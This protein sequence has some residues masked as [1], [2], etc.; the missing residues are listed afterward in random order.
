MSL[1][2][3]CSLVKVELK[4]SALKNDEKLQKMDKRKTKREEEEEEGA[5]QQ[6]S[7]PAVGGSAAQ[8]EGVGQQVY[9]QVVDGG[10]AAPHTGEQ[11]EH[12]NGR[13]TSER[14]SSGPEPSEVRRREE[15]TKRRRK[16]E[17]KEDP[18]QL[19][20]P[21]YLQENCQQGRKDEN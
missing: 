5:G 17:P 16:L 1:P 8:P 20:L 21:S 9:Q 14:A 3:L 13:E 18:K 7:R 10:A 12:R 15:L 2:C 19:K 4:I 6:D 11:V